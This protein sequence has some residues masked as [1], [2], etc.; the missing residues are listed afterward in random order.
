MIEPDLKAL[1]RY[2]LEQLLRSDRRAVTEFLL[3][4]LSSSAERARTSSDRCKRVEAELRRRS[5]RLRPQ[6]SRGADS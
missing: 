6:K 4:P 3:N 1:S 2:D 5:G